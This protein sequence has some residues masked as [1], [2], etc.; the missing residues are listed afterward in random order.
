[1][2]EPIDAY[3]FDMDD[4]LVRSGTTWQQAEVTLLT[5]IG[6]QRTPE[7]AIQY[8]GMNA[9]VVAATIHRCDRPSEIL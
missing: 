1:M 7:L 9:L 2:S 3:I 8:K 6:H 4:L 5:Q